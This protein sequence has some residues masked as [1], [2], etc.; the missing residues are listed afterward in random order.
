MSGCRRF[1]PRVPCSES[2]GQ[3]SESSPCQRCQPCHPGWSARQTR[4][5]PVALPLLPA[6]YSGV[7]H[8]FRQVDKSAGLVVM[9]GPV[10]P[11]RTGDG[12]N[13]LPDVGEELVPGADQRGAGGRVRGQAGDPPWRSA[14]PVRVGAGRTGMAERRGYASQSCLVAAGL[15]ARAR[16]LCV[17]PAGLARRVSAR[18]ACGLAVPRSGGSCGPGPVCAFCDCALAAAWLVRKLQSATPANHYKSFPEIYC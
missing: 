13:R 4:A 14:M 8:R 16:R 10:R 3:Q 11:P 12:R 9:T 17:G 18:F 1:G 7:L 2:A 6:A 5:N 15:A